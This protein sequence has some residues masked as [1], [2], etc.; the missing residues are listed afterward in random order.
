MCF[1]TLG[2]A[3]ADNNH[4]LFTIA[5]DSGHHPTQQG[6]LGVKG[7]YEVIYNDKLTAQI[8]EALKNAGF[9]VILTRTPIQTISLDERARIA[10]TNNADL[11]IAIHHDS[12]QQPYLKKNKLH[13]EITAYETIKSISG[14]SLFVSMKNPDFERSF[15]F[16]Q[17]L[18][19][20]MLKLGRPP[21]LHHAENIEGENRHLL[22]Q[23][24]GIYQFDDLIVLKKTLMPAI[25]LEIGVIVDKNDEAYVSNQ[26]N[27]KR[28][29]D[30]IV[31]S[32]QEYHSRT[33]SA[34][35]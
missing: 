8:A 10:N 9:S 26:E 23:T 19:E 3:K 30:T 34:L 7:V 25:L 28:I 2:C 24:L 31:S 4:R 21:S 1:C 22:N 20:K 18:G 6:A 29:V 32:I 14:Y 16:A 11:F 33:K 17:I 12:A 13:S 5:L 15:Q 35:E 27:Q